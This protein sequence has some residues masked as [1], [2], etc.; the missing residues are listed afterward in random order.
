MLAVLRIVLTLFVVLT[1]STCDTGCLRKCVS[2]CS[3]RFSHEK[4]PPPIILQKADRGCSLVGQDFLKTM[5][6]PNATVQGTLT[7]GML[8]F[9][10]GLTIMDRLLPFEIAHQSAFHSSRPSSAV[11]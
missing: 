4:R 7:S 9:F 3:I 10:S 8:Y 11:P 1:I 6:N 5:G 2:C